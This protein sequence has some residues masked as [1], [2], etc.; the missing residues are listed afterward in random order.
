MARHEC[1]RCGAITHDSDGEHLCADI[2]RRYE[3][4]ERQIAAVEAILLPGSIVGRDTRTLAEAIVKRLNN[5]GIT[6]D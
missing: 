1:V 6:E 4:Q 5:L 2:K 3:R